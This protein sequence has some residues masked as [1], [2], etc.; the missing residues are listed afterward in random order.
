MALL[1]GA[2]MGAM[3]SLV[4]GVSGAEAATININLTSANGTNVSV[5]GLAG[6]QTPL[7]ANGTAFNEVNGSPNFA[8]LRDSTGA[9]TGI[10]VETDL[11]GNSNFSFGQ[12]GNVPIVQNYWAGNISFGNP[13]AAAISTVTFSNL[14][15]GSIWNIVAV[16]QGDSDG[17]G[18]ALTIDGVTEISQGSDADGSDFTDAFT[19]G[20]N[21]VLFESVVASSRGQIIADVAAGPGDV[22]FVVLNAL[23]LVEVPEPTAGL[24]AGLS[25]LA[26]VSRRRS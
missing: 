21:F 22:N 2:L 26:I 10:S 16:A 11:N 9:L 5:D 12:A 24:L 19:E 25:L 13:P 15:P 6:V 8:D 14:T 20:V 4:F 3:C 17:Q 1:R 7:P 18:A 23:Q